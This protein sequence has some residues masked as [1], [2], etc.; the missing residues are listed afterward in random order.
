MSGFLT[1]AQLM[2]TI[3]TVCVALALCGCAGAERD[4]SAAGNISASVTDAVM[5]GAR[6]KYRAQVDDTKCREFGF[7][8]KT[9]GYADCRLELEAIAPSPRVSRLQWFSPATV[10]HAEAIQNQ[11]LGGC[12]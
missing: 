6:Q 3:A 10:R 5:P 4:G 1:E 9:Q 2:R 12:A 8:P 11:A 7:E